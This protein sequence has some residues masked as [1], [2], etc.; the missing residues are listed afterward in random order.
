M[1]LLRHRE[2]KYFGGK[3]V[4]RFKTDLNCNEQ[5]KTYYRFQ[6]MRQKIFFNSKKSSYFNSIVISVSISFSV[7]IIIDPIFYFSRYIRFDRFCNFDHNINF[8]GDISG[9]LEDF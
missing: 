6:L 4:R 8:P 7:G 9:F 3:L 1:L 2:S 5:R